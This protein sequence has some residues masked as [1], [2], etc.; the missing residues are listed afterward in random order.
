MFKSSFANGLLNNTTENIAE[1]L[2]SWDKLGIFTQLYKKLGN[3]IEGFFSSEEEIK[4][5]EVKE[6][7]LEKKKIFIHF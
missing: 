5:N 4:K 2:V 1:Y 7:F 3:F 6:L